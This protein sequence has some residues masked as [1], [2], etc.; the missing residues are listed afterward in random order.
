MK[1]GTK[2]HPK[3]RALARRLMPLLGI[4]RLEHH[5]HT[6]RAELAQ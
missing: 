3:M 4:E 6:A 1:R 5:T 2:D